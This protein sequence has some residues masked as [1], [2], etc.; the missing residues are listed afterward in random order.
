MFV[1]LLVGHQAKTAFQAE[2]DVVCELADFY[3][4]HGQF[5]LDLV[6]IQ[7]VSTE[8]SRNSMLYRGMEGF[9]AAISPFNFT[10]IGGNL[11]G[12]PAM[13]VSLLFR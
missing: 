1:C 3:R 8:E 9:V 2:L 4:F 13:M 6:N 11:A 12:T 7:P 10:A 5:A